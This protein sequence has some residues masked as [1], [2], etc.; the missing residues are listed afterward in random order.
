VVACGGVSPNDVPPVPYSGALPASVSARYLFNVLSVEA[1]ANG[2]KASPILVDTGSPMTGLDPTS[3]AGGEIPPDISVLSSL[4]VGGVTFERVPAVALEECGTACGPFDV[5]GVLGGNVLRSFTLALDYR[6][7]AVVFGAAAIPASAQSTPSVI[8]FAVAGGGTGTI[9]GGDGRTL[10]VPPTRILVQA[11]I[12]GSVRTLLLDTGS[13][14]TLLRDSLFSALVADGRAQLAL[15]AS[16]GAGPTQGAVARTKTLDVS[17][18]TA[19]GSVVGS[20][21][22]AQVDDVATET[23]E[24][25]D[26]MLGGSF[27]RASYTVVDYAAGKLSLYPY[28]TVDPLVDEFV[29]AGVFLD[30]EG[31]GYVVS[32]AIDPAAGAFVG[33]AVADVDGTA[34]ANLDPEQ[35]D[36]LLRGQVGASHVIHFEG[37]GA[38]SVTL[39]VKDVLPLAP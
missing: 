4:A 18:A 1:V 34:V 11:T 7:P 31:D 3:Y 36:R 12:E 19:T 27:L 14:Y 26:G 5:T 13:S 21:P 28:A 10:D 39:A 15:E 22:D 38:A 9:A 23:G 25:V 6:A 33:S 37:A 17:S 16:T 2:A 29:R 24:T 8:S 35:A 30:E 20:V 32:Q